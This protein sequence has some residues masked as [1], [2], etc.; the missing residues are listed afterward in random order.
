MAARKWRRLIFCGYQLN[1]A[2]VH[3]EFRQEG[4]EAER[5][6]EL[7]N[8]RRN[9]RVSLRRISS[10]APAIGQKPPGETPCPACRVSLSRG[11]CWQAG[12]CAAS[13]LRCEDLSS[14]HSLS[15]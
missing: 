15:D 8:P 2:C 11:N 9:H 6:S 7:S 12:T 13:T 1:R 10:L 5:S 3:T 4:E 14:D